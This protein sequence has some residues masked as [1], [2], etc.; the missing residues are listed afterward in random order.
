V[1]GRQG[2]EGGLRPGAAEYKLAIDGDSLSENAT[3]NAVE[4][5][6]SKGK[7][8]DEEALSLNIPACRG[9]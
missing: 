8:S 3:R 9:E 1:L 5:G 7:G 2:L 6:E 4:R